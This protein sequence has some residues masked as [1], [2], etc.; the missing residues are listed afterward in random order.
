MSRQTMD[1]DSIVALWLRGTLRRPHMD[2]VTRGHQ[3]ACDKPRVVTDTTRLRWILTRNQL[4]DSQ[5]EFSLP[6][7][8][9]RASLAQ[10]ILLSGE[11]NC[12]QAQ[13]VEEPDRIAKFVRVPQVGVELNHE[14]KFFPLFREKPLETTQREEFEAFD[15]HH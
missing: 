3:T 4:P 5:A 13:F 12:M 9:D 2:F 10:G 1:D 15:I 11:R 6:G 7:K 14:P 8:I